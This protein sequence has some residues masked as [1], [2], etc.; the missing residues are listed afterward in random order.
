MADDA[1]KQKYDDQQADWVIVTPSTH[2]IV[3]IWKK[4]ITGMQTLG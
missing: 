2:F 4:A 3:N 1:T